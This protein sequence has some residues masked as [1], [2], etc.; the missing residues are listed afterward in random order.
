MV[1][2][3]ASDGCVGDCVGVV[4]ECVFVLCAGVGGGGDGSN[5]DARISSTSCVCE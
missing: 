5:C 2:G 1:C 3:E 4:S